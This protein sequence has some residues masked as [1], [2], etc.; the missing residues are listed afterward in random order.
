MN[1][2]RIVLWSIIGGIVV[3]GIVIAFARPT[4]IHR[5]EQITE[6]DGMRQ[7]DDKWFSVIPLSSVH[8]DPNISVTPGMMAELGRAI[9]HPAGVDLNGPDFAYRNIYPRKS[10]YI[11]LKAKGNIAAMLASYTAQ[12]KSPRAYSY[13]RG[14]GLD[15]EITGLS[16]NGVK[17]TIQLWDSTVVR[18]RAYDP[19]VGLFAFE[20]DQ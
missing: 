9:R 19:T 15:A 2:R 6:G 4:W 17:L 12:L 8:R 3:I 11:R 14:S 10:C 13:A 16:A 1:R 7:S 20:W 18:G 5:V